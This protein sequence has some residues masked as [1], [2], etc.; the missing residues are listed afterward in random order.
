MSLVDETC[1][2]IA[3]FREGLIELWDLESSNNKSE[4]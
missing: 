4:N 3:G 1:L 2:V